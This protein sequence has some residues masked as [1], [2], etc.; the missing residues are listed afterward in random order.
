[1]IYKLSFTE[2]NVPSLSTIT[3]VGMA[4]YSDDGRKNSPVVDLVAFIFLYA[5]SSIALTV[6]EIYRQISRISLHSFRAGNCTNQSFEI[7]V[8]LYLFPLFNVMD[9]LSTDTD[10]YEKKLSLSEIIC[11]QNRGNYWKSFFLI[12]I[13][14]LSRST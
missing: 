7:S 9:T 14:F 8:Y 3:C 5:W 1:M 4:W 13:I 12:F 10:F 6:A 2:A 11:I